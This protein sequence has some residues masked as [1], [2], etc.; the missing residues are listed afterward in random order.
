MKLLISIIEFVVV[1]AIAVAIL[2]LLVF[3]ASASTPRQSASV[4]TYAWTVQ[5]ATSVTGPWTTVTMIYSPLANCRIAL[6][7]TNGAAA[8]LN[9]YPTYYKTQ[10]YRMKR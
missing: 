4:G 9:L 2:L 5:G 7:S 8:V 3:P 1:A 10:F 6:G